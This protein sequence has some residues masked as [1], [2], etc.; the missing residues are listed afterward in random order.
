MLTSRTAILIIPDL[1][2]PFGP[3]NQITVILINLQILQNIR[4]IFRPLDLFSLESRM[5]GPNLP[6][7]RDDPLSHA[8][9]QSLALIIDQVVLDPLEEAF[10]DLD[11]ALDMAVQAEVE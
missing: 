10:V 2:L 11:V 5:Y 9:H 8:D 6:L 1:P 7:L 4:I 3:D